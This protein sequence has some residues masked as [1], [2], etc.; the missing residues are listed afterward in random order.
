MGVVTYSSARQR[1]FSPSAGA[2]ATS[3][4]DGSASGLR[5]SA[6]VT[7][8]QVGVAVVERA[9]LAVPAFSVAAAC[10]PAGCRGAASFVAAV[11]G[12]GDRASSAY[13]LP[14]AILW[15]Y[16]KREGGGGLGD[17]I[18]RKTLFR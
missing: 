18:S 14:P 6:C 15:C 7:R 10:G 9:Q 8:D 3:W 5:C 17:N 2:A 12:A 16:K 1:F 11:A 4:S 13:G